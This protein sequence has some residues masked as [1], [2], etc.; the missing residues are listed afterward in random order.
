MEG[1]LKESTDQLNSMR[2]RLKRTRDAGEIAIPSARDV[3]RVVFRH[4][5]AI[6]ITA[7]VIIGFG[8]TAVK[9]MPDQYESE[10]RLYLRPERGDISI[11]PTSQGLVTASAGRNSNAASNELSILGS[12]VLHEQVVREVG[13]EIVLGFSEDQTIASEFKDDPNPEE[14]AVRVAARVLGLAT[15]S[16]VEGDIVVVKYQNPDPK[17]AQSVVAKLVECYMERHLQVHRSSVDPGIFRKEADA[18][19]IKIRAKEQE[20]KSYHEG[21][22]VQ[23]VQERR[24]Q[25]LSFKSSYQAQVAQNR[26][27]QE[28]SQARINSLEVSLSPEEKNSSIPPTQM[29]NPD[30]IALR[31]HLTTLEI[32][33]MKLESVFTGGNQL[34]S[35]NYQI[36]ETKQ[37]INSLPP[38]VPRRA[39]GTSTGFGED[40]LLL[41]SNERINLDALKATGVALTSELDNVLTELG[42]L[43][44][45]SRSQAIEQ[46]LTLLRADYERTNAAYNDVA[47]NARLDEEKISNVSVLNPASLP[48]EPIG[49]R[50][51]RNL[52][53]VVFVAV[54]AGIGV[55]ILREFLDDTLKTRDDVE[56]KLGIPVLAVVPAE[57]F[58]K[59]I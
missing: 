16:S 24:E 46:E 58:R 1:T 54:A 5:V 33:K 10:A 8:A 53:L 47:L 49:P 30:V 25:L 56:R 15:Q 57:E 52:A 35:I 36:A 21:S 39:V 19:L 50:R 11:D 18:I 43:G 9:M 17:I 23:S 12:R 40:P 2:E 29:E 42:S 51:M 37:K 38:T 4:K 45:D 41:L 59:C 26:V 27:D 32:E 20:L 48:D 3:L 22:N 31:E 7:G 55:A 14:A 6:L 13:P 28:A 34:E 44:D